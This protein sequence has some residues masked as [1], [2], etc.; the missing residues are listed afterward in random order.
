M[1]C[2]FDAST[3]T[4]GWAITD[5]NNICDAGFIDIKT[6]LTNKEKSLKVISIIES[7]PL[8]PKIEK[9][10]LEAA[11]SGY[12][13]GFTSQQVIITLSRFNAVFEYIIS[14]KWNK[15]VIL[16]N[17]NTVRKNVLGKCREKGIKSKVFVE[18]YLSKIQNIHKF[19]IM[20]K[21]GEPDKRNADMYDAIILSL[22]K[23]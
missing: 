11:L 7:N 22:F 2:G 12:A 18:S 1:I 20:N 3:S 6:C 17:V 10:H 19:D 8:F 16:L 23:I 13:G 4:V 21:R 14:E 15:P 5:G 9:F